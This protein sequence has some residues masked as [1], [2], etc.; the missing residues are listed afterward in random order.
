MK[1]RKLTPIIMLMLYSGITL[2]AD[3]F[4]E[5][6]KT[7]LFV[8][9]INMVMKGTVKQV[10]D[11]EIVF[12]NRYVLKESKAAATVTN[13]D[14]KSGKIKSLAMANYLKST[15]KAALLESG[16]LKDV[17]TSYSRGALTAIKV[18]E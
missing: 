9:R 8:P 11:H 3:E 14:A 5:V 4:F 10:T 17:P 6:G 2:A 16:P 1:F 7:Y 13:D 12:T 15:N 18:D